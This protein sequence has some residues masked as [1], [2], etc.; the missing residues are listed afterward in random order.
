VPIAILIPSVFQMNQAGRSWQ[1]I[2][3]GVFIV[4]RNNDEIQ[5]NS[6]TQKKGKNIPGFF[7]IITA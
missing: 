5:C 1:A 3:S 7:K 6:I 4:I 2:I